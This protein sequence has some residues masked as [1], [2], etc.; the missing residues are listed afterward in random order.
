M[1]VLWMTEAIPLPVTALLPVFVYPAAGI[2]PAHEVASYYLTDSNFVFFGSLIMAVAIENSHLHERIAL[3]ILLL[4]GSNPR[5]LMLGFQLATC[6]LSMWMSNTATTAMMVPIAMAVIHELH[7]FQSEA[8]MTSSA[9]TGSVIKV[10]DNPKSFNSEDRL[11][12]KELD[13]ASIPKKELDVYKG[14]LLSICYAATIGGTGTLIG[15]GPNIVLSGELDKFYGGKTEITFASWILFATPQMLVCLLICWLW[16]QYLFIGKRQHTKSDDRIKVML[17]KKYDHLGSM[18]FDERVVFLFFLLLVA[19]WLFRE[20]KIIPGWNHL[21][22]EGF[23]TDGTTVMFV[24]FLLF[25]FPAENPFAP[26]GSGRCK[27]LMNWDLMQKKFSWSTVMLLGGGFAMAA[28]VRES[29]LSDL[30]GHQMASLTILPTWAFLALSVTIITF[31]TEFSS[32]VATASIF[33]PLIAGVAEQTH[34]NPLYYILPVTISCSFAFM[35]P[36]GT[37]PN[38][39][40]FSAKILHVMDMVKAGFFMNTISIVITIVCTHTWAY[41]LF[42]LGSFP[43]WAISPTFNGSVNAS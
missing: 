7:E 29:G 14:I 22:D 37:P 21:F 16:L 43:D 41:W 38:A 36:A 20:P 34:I 8:K 23:V 40:V 25:V 18:R 15:T 30:I 32:N 11:S 13:I 42:N 31:I 24:A 10:E 1:G 4:T 6:V 9:S 27:T 5:W 2:L 28:G 35:L 33:I 3:R 17:R 12:F 26:S 19:L 39:I